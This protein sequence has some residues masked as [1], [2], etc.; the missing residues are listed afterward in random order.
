MLPDLGKCLLTW[1]KFYLDCKE[2]GLR[3]RQLSVNGLKIGWCD[4]LTCPKNS[5]EKLA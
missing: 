2:D 5:S 1:I 3:L 4:Y